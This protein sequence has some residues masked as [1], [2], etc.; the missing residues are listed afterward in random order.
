VETNP[1]PQHY[2]IRGVPIN[3]DFLKMANIEFADYIFVFAN[4][5]FQEPDLKTLHIISRI[6]K[7]NSQARIFVE[8]KDTESE[9]AD[10]LDNSIIKMNSRQLLKSVLKENSLNLFTY[11]HTNTN[12]EKVT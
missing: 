2:F 8:L 5:R 10:Y 11:L 1:Y 12:Q 7:F 9:L 6:Q 4:A 3:P